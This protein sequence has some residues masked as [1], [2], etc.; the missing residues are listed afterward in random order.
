MNQCEGRLNIFS[1]IQG[2]KKFATNTPFLR[3]PLLVTCYQ[4]TEVNQERIFGFKTK[5]GPPD[6]RDESLQ[7]DA[8]ERAQDDNC[9][10]GLE[11]NHFILEQVGRLGEISSTR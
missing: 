2:L 8:D 5:V 11:S 10:V 4:N 3:K 6:S 7:H 1:D 9:A